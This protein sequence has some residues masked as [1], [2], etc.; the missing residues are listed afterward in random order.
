[1]VNDVS[2]GSLETQAEVGPVLCV[3]ALPLSPWLSLSLGPF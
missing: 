2:W 3:P 1:M